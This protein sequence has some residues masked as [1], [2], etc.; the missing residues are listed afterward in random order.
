MTYLSKRLFSALLCFLF[1]LALLPGAFS[2]T[3]KKDSLGQTYDL[4]TDY[5]IT[6]YPDATGQ[7]GCFYTIE[8]DLYF[9]I[10]DGGWAGNADAVRDVIAAHDNHVDAWIISH[11]HQDHAGAFNEIAA[12]PR[13]ITIDRIY[14]NGFDYD[15]VEASGEPYDDLTV[16]E[17]F[18]ALTKDSDH[19]THLKRGDSLTVCGLTFDVY[20]AFDDSVLANVGGEKDYQNNASLLLRITN[21]RDSILFCSDIKYDMND[22]LSASLTPEMLSST[23]VQLGHHG[24]WSFDEDFYAKTGADIF[25]LDAPSN[26]SDNPDFPASTLKTDLLAQNKTVLDYSTAPHSVVLK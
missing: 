10:F 13:A 15:F 25:F 7:H 22:F 20:N 11:P 14:D 18:H 3:V 17:T 6:Q 2:S 4:S 8:N 16:M 12:D 24:N 19:V 9:L 1:L 21:R 26:I 5:L 23:Y